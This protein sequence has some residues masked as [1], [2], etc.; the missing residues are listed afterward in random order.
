M[1]NLEHT[2]KPKS[3]TPADDPKDPR[4]RK[5]DT[6]IGTIKHT[7]K[8][9][10]IAKKLSTQTADRN[11]ITERE[12]GPANSPEDGYTDERERDA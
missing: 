8:Q 5:K 3:R 6:M 7:D 10:G 9:E 4:E 12:R 2:Q 1:R 11:P